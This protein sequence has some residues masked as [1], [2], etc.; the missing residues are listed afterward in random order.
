MKK[1]LCIC[2]F[3]LS[4][5]MSFS[6]GYPD[7]LNLLFHQFKDEVQTVEIITNQVNYSVYSCL[8]HR[9]VIVVVADDYIVLK[10]NSGN[11]IIAIGNIVEVTVR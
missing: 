11:V 5:A 8:Y 3:V 4:M 7:N 2:I 9:G 1:I 10:E 6:Y